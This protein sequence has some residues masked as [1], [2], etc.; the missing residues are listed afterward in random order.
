MKFNCKYYDIIKIEQEHQTTFLIDD[1][2][3][4]Y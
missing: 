2:R 4:G 3:I 1:K